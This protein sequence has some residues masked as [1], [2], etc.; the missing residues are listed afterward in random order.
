ML[1]AF[2]LLVSHMEWKEPTFNQMSVVHLLVQ[3]DQ[4]EI[5]EQIKCQKLIWRDKK[6]FN[7]FLN[8]YKII[9]EK[10]YH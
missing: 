10:D 5:E 3:A 8:S 2:I 9:S 1:F 4:D 6:L 7:V